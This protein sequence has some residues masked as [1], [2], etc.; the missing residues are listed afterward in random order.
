MK[1]FFSLFLAALMLMSVLAGCAKEVDEQI[2][3]ETESTETEAKKDTPADNGD[4]EDVDTPFDESS[5]TGTKFPINNTASWFKKLDPRM[6]ATADHVTCDWSASGIEFVA[7]CKGDVTFHINANAAKYQETQGCYFRAYVDGDVYMNGNSPYYEVSGSKITL[8]DLPEGE[9][10]IRIVKATGYQLAL[11]ELVSVYLTGT[12]NDTAPADKDLFIEFVGDS[13]SCGWGLIGTHDGKY[14]SQ[15]ATLAYPYLLASALNADY[16]ILGVSGQGIATGNPQIDN[17]Y[18]YASIKRSTAT[19]YGFERKADIVVINADTNDAWRSQPVPEKVFID[20][21]K[22]LVEY[23]RAKNGDETK[24]ILVCGMIKTT[25]AEAISNLVTEL[26]GEDENYYYF[27]ATTCKGEYGGHPN[28]AENI[29]YTGF[30]KDL[31]TGNDP[32]KYPQLTTSLYSQ[33][34]SSDDGHVK[35][36]YGGAMNWTLEGGVLNIPNVGWGSSTGPALNPFLQIVDRSIFADVPDKYM[37]EMELDIKKH[38]TISIMLNGSVDASTDTT[39]TTRTG[40]AVIQFKI[41]GDAK[42]EISNLNDGT[43]RFYVRTGYVDNNA[44]TI[45]SAYGAPIYTIPQG[46]TSATF[47]ISIVVDSSVQNGCNIHIFINET[48]ISTRSFEGDKF[49]VTSNSYVSLWAQESSLTID[50]LKVLK[51]D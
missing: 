33:D 26:G 51:I 32:T 21:Y 16:S 46:A 36:I 44:C 37:I 9:H 11:A 17:A 5:V 41:D 22:A 19:E 7:N 39:Y 38:N 8:K 14:T 48:Y 2:D 24:I 15:D 47:K 31:I 13:I 42:D 3:A 45:A 6:E 1:K 29:S 40:A 35:K 25:Y 28:E 43:K 27:K 30:L 10:T 23:V 34:F 20:E 12:V 50:N 49:D 4:G 18:K